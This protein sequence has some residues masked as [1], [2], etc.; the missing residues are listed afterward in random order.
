MEE[1][2]IFLEK[3][4]K[5]KIKTPLERGF[6]IKQWIN[7][8][9]DNFSLADNEIFSAGL[10]FNHTLDEVRNELKKIY[11]EENPFSNY[12]E[13]I[14]FY[15][16]M[17]NRD[18]SLLLNSTSE[19]LSENNTLFSRTFR[20]NVFQNE[21]TANDIVNGCVEGVSKALHMCIKNKHKKIK[22]SNNPLSKLQ[23]IMKESYLSQ[24]YSR[25]E[26]YWTLLIFHDYR[27]LIEGKDKDKF[28]VVYEP[29]SE[30][31][32]M[33]L[34]SNERRER[35]TVH[36]VAT[37]I[38][39]NNDLI[40]LMKNKIIYIRNSKA[41]QV[42]KSSKDI[43]EK[44][45]IAYISIVTQEVYLTKYLPKEF[46]ERNGENTEFSVLDILKVFKQLSFLAVQYLDDYTTFDSEIKDEEA[47][48]LLKFCPILKKR[49]LIKSIVDVTGYKFKKVE[50]IL[51]FLEY[52]G[53]D[54]NDFWCNPLHSLSSTEY[55]LLASA[56][57]SSILLRVIE[58]WLVQL[59]IPLHKKGI[60]YELT[61][62]DSFNKILN[63][64]LNK[65]D[66]NEAITKKIKLNKKIEEI[67]FLCKIGN[68]ILLG[69]AKCIIS[70]DSPTSGY[71]TYETLEHASNQVRRKQKFVETNLQ[72]IFKILKWDFSSEEDYEIIGFILNSN[73]TFIGLNIE[74]VPIIDE[75]ILSNYF[76]S[77]K[78]PFIN[79]SPNPE[80]ALASFVLYENSI[81]MLN[82]FSKYIFNP[83]QVTI[84]KNLFRREIIKSPF[85]NEKSSKIVLSKLFTT[86][87]NMKKILESEHIFPIEKV[88][89]IDKYLGDD[90]IFL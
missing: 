17:S 23:F 87:I 11:E 45:L 8:F 55:I 57:D 9:K 52:T 30:Y 63:K 60:H 76:K 12:D 28:Y 36:R 39:T 72:D 62:I 27:F 61:I 35:V 18:K 26:N 78:S 74:G 90:T 15:F 43:N 86:K 80:E 77:N 5:K 54:K 20:N 1:E 47:D 88:N 34:I 70:S 84:Y 68:K 33:F 64:N 50:E 40:K 58:N 13:L 53:I 6:N 25:I 3:I 59:K 38:A 29:N 79:A 46:L 51:S 2:R 16:A 10:I 56:I 32:Q 82:N 22:V 48:K 85:L 89:D 67:D 49:K 65:N 75:M 19:I 66:F 4:R 42:I 24:M 21:L 71:R 69:E 44:I 37:S 83:P 14:K 41:F 31:E 7:D 73:K 81:E